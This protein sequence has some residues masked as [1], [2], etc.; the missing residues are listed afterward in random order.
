MRL[1]T[2]MLFLL[3][4]FVGVFLHVSTFLH[5]LSFDRF[6]RDI[7]SLYTGA[8]IVA[9]MS[10]LG[11]MKKRQIGAI[12]GTVIGMLVW[13]FLHRLIWLYDFDFTPFLGVQI[14]FLILVSAT[15][16]RMLFLDMSRDD[17]EQ[18]E[19]DPA[20]ARRLHSAKQGLHGKLYPSQDRGFVRDNDP[21]V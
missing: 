12:A 4:L 11:A 10:A 5:E 9:F 7:V 21:R 17:C 8:C 16:N 20:D 18:R 19:I 3:T 6:F 13:G 2:R 14:L 1:N 15:V